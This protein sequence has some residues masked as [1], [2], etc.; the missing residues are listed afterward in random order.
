MACV[1]HAQKQLSIA[2]RPSHSEA[3]G[4]GRGE[5]HERDPR[6]ELHG[7]HRE[8]RYRSSRGRAPEG[9]GKRRYIANVRHRDEKQAAKRSDTIKK[10]S[11]TSPLSD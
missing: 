11:M 2:N 1:E 10:S 9:S 6:G 7:K 5:W 8:K 4:R 3:I